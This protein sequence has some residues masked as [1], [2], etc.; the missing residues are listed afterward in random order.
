[1]DYH[2][3]TYDGLRRIR[4]GIK[5][6]PID[7]SRKHALGWLG[8]QE[9]KFLKSRAELETAIIEGKYTTTLSM[10]TEQELSKLEEAWTALSRLSL[11]QASEQSVES[12]QSKKRKLSTAFGAGVVTIGTV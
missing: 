4:N 5:Y 1:M 11:K 3:V 8:A 7:D 2:G 6:W 12:D 10:A 9:N